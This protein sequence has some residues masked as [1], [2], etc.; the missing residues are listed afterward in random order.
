MPPIPTPDSY[1][2]TPGVA[3]YAGRP[4]PDPVEP[5]VLRLY[6]WQDPE[7]PTLVGS[8]ALDVEIDPLTFQDTRLSA[9][10]GT[11]AIKQSNDSIVYGMGGDAFEF[12]ATLFRINGALNDDVA[13]QPVYQV[14]VACKPYGRWSGWPAFDGYNA[15]TDSTIP[16]AFKITVE[17]AGGAVLHTF[18]MRDGLAINY[19][20]AEQQVRSTTKPARPPF[21]CAMMLPWQS[22]RLKVSSDL[23]FWFPGVRPESVNLRNNR[24]KVSSVGAIPL[25]QG[26]T[27]INGALHWYALPEWPLPYDLAYG[28]T[29]ELNALDPNT[30]DPYLFAVTEY[31]GEAASAKSWRMSGWNYEPG[32]ISGHDWYPGPGGPRFDRSYIPTSLAL[33]ATNPTG[34]RPKNSESLRDMAEAWS[35]AYFNVPTNLVTD[36]KTLG[37]IPK[38]QILGRQW[39]QGYSGYYGQGSN[40]VTGGSTRHVNFFAIP[41]GGDWPAP[42]KDGLRHFNGVQFD[43]QHN[44]SQPGWATLLL[45]S[46]MHV[47]AARLRFSTNTMSWLGA[48]IANT[49]DIFGKRQQAWRWLHYAMQWALGTTHEFGY[50][51]G[52]IEGMLQI[53]LEAIH[54]QV[55]VPAF[56]DLSSDAP[57]K[58][59]RDLGIFRTSALTNSGDG[60]VFVQIPTPLWFYIAGPLHMMKQSGMLAAMMAKNTKCQLAI[61]MIIECLDKWSCDFIVATNGRA[62][63]VDGDSITPYDNRLSTT[64]PSGQTPVIPS[65]WA[66]WAAIYPA[67]G[68][69]SWTK[70]PDGTMANRTAPMHCRAQW[71]FIRRDYFAD[72]N[73]GRANIGAACDIYDALYSGRTD[74]AWQYRVP[75]HGILNQQV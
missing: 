16:K 42:D 64:V 71:A 9:E 52:E 65:S 36:V 75:S 43:D 44:Y 6:D 45:N 57:F 55:Y 28:S 23:N 66:E 69:E 22:A 56:V 51:R 27:Q 62:E 54:D 40:Y 10:I 48:G 74:G 35:N 11:V 15:A 68:Q 21:N 18:E 72:V 24:A 38:S 59:L 49:T 73:P 26:R 46:P 41:N 2:G 29:P 12:G 5:R 58:P 33:F 37:T 17:T 50:S 20:P 4:T 3:I 25:M 8:V 53:E 7:L 47:Y 19:N 34:T 61:E 14:L 63:F 30:G 32:S 39:S 67:I 70:K 31:T 13:G 1:P 60:N